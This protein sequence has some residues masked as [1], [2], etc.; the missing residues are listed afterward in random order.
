MKTEM[1]AFVPLRVRLKKAYAIGIVAFCFQA[2]SV[3]AQVS[4]FQAAIPFPFVVGTQT[5]PPG[6]YVVQRYLGRPKH[7]DQ[8]GVIVMKDGN[9]HIYKVIV[10]GAGKQGDAGKREG[11]RLVF[12]SFR[13]KQY[14]NRVL[15]AGDPVA[16]QLANLPV[17]IAAAGASGE[18][19]V[20]S[21]RSSGGN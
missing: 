16:H 14:L 18:V 2:A 12:T 1:G 17:E 8:P 6:I 21:P 7:A 5:L 3:Y 15:V 20:T 4:S 11:S 9:R 10:T 19:I 13:G